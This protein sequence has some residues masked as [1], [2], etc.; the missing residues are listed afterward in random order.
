MS[1]AWAGVLGGALTT[2]A[3]SYLKTLIDAPDEAVAREKARL[4]NERIKTQM[5]LDQARAEWERRRLAGHPSTRPLTVRTRRGD[6][7]ERDPGTGE[8]TVVF[9]APAPEPK[10]L[11]PEQE[12]QSTVLGTIERRL[13]KPRK[14]WTAEDVLR[15]DV[16][17]LI[18]LVQKRSDIIVVPGWGPMSAEDIRKKLEEQRPPH[19]PPPGAGTPSS[20]QAPPGRGGAVS[21]PPAGPTGTR[22]APR[23]GGKVDVSAPDYWD[24]QYKTLSPAALLEELDAAL[25][26]DPQEQSIVTR[27][28]RAA[29]ERRLEALGAAPP[30]APPQSQAPA[31]PGRQS[32]LEE[33]PADPRY[34]Q[35]YGR[36]MASITPAGARQL[37]SALTQKDPTS[38]LARAAQ[39]AYGQVYGQ[40]LSE[41]PLDALT[42][43]PGW[44]ETAVQPREPE[45]AQA[46][47]V[48]V[49]GPGMPS[50]G[51]A[52]GQEAQARERSDLAH[53]L[54][55]ELFDKQLGELSQQEMT[56]LNRELARREAQTKQRYEEELKN[57]QPLQDV[58]PQDFDRFFDR[59]T[60]N[61]V[62]G[63]TRY[64][65]VKTRQE[66]PS[67][68]TGVVHL[69]TDNA[70]TLSVLKLLEPTLA[71]YRELIQYAY[72]TDPQTGKPGP[73]A[74]YTRNPLLTIGAMWNQAWQSDPVL[75]SK[76]RAVQ[77]QLQS[78]VRALGSRGDLNAQELE[79]ATGLIA[80]MDASLGIGLTGG[81]GWGRGGI[82]PM[83]G[84]RPTIS[85]PDTPDTGLKVA[86]ELIGVVN[87]R[88]GTLL[89]N[90]RYDVTKEIELPTGPTAIGP[91]TKMSPEELR[92]V[93]ESALA[94]IRSLRDL[95]GSGFTEEQQRVLAVR[96]KERL[97]SQAE[98]R[99]LPTGRTSTPGIPPALQP[100]W[101]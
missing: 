88:I 21:P 5:D 87:N 46:G 48:R 30:Q 92:T 62:P 74:G 37:V 9:D 89:Q 19:A 95:V 6:L 7:L 1:P 65:L 42:R 28:K 24:T 26:L 50:L 100:L 49:A 4:E 57:Q 10:A 98:S 41:A 34:V 45:E 83:V 55:R 23:R 90:P 93:P 22:P 20:P 59:K 61:P 47:V 40:P 60:G 97:R 63:T 56:T 16:R 36:Q 17:P 78:L 77:G 91:L 71:Q 96:L 11:T 76:R 44:E 54:S 8:W 70:K 53:R 75:E 84:F 67:A 31:A 38:P 39:A 52:P 94:P 99:G 43:Q 29:I 69:T 73:L 27:K 14:E 81:V 66:D 58:R 12:L 35:A 79:A 64:G 3:N 18:D 80:N 68:E 2:G 86:N 32:L 51:P 33:E 85:I 101:P 15:P 13:G 82:G 25:A 72:G